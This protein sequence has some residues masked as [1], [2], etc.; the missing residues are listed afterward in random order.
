MVE[1]TLSNTTLKSK[2]LKFSMNS[3][4]QLQHHQGK[5]GYQNGGRGKTPFPFP[6]NRHEK[7]ANTT[8]QKAKKVP[9]LDILD[10]RN[11]EC[12]PGNLSNRKYFKLKITSQR[13]KSSKSIPRGQNITVQ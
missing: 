9:H 6:N 8:F 3:K 1:Q 10:I 5:H 12:H 7:A 11:T 2:E 13:E 4:N